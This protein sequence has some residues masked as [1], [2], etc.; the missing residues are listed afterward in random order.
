MIKGLYSFHVLDIKIK[1]QIF[2]LF[3]KS[4]VC[5]SDNNDNEERE[6]DKKQMSDTEKEKK[7]RGK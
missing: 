3:I 5:I 1:G 7:N 4:M 2:I 6:T